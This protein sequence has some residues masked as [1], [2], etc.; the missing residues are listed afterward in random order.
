M[1]ISDLIVVMNRGV[2][3]QIGKPQEVYDNPKN[4]F[5]SK[6]L[7]TPP[8]NVFEG[9]V[10]SGRLYIGDDAV[11]DCTAPAGEYYI[12][13]RPE[14]FV[15]ARDGALCAS[16]R[17]V[18]VMGRD[19]SVIFERE[20]FDTMRAIIPSDASLDVAGGEIRFNIK[21]EKLFLFDKTTEERVIF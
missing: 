14:G 20:G 8:I 15:P 6:F 1:S 16:L 3:Q 17:G 9:R 7:G 10:E 21:R 11:L 13:I 5:V 12:G 4:L 18:E 19:T 2:V